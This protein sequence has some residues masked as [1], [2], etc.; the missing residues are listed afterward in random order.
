MFLLSYDSEQKSKL[1]EFA[2]ET[3]H[4]RN[5][6]SACIRTNLYE[7]WGN[8]VGKTCDSVSD[9]LRIISEV[10]TSTDHIPGKESRGTSWHENNQNSF[11][12]IDKRRLINRQ[13]FSIVNWL[14][15][16]TTR[17]S[18]LLYTKRHFK[19]NLKAIS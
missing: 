13:V 5:Y 2:W 18:R 10:I 14:M 17:N 16:N 19:L 4:C 15:K 6:P 9:I 3:I 11:M 12:Q 8:L 7:I 1:S